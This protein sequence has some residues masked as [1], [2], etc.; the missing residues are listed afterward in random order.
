M[1]TKKPDKTAWQELMASLGN[2]GEIIC[3]DIDCENKEETEVTEATLD[4]SQKERQE[5]SVHWH[6]NSDE[7]EIVLQ[8][9][10]VRIGVKNNEEGELALFSDAIG[11]YSE[12]TNKEQVFPFNKIK[13][14]R[15]FEDSLRIWFKGKLL[16]DVFEGL[17]NT[18]QWKE[19]LELRMAKHI[20]STEQTPV[21][22]E[23][24][25]QFCGKKI[26]RNSKFCN[27][28]GQENKYRSREE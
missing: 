18:F 14:V 2:E 28:C 17:E 26:L 20:M 6:F 4:L 7:K 24:F 3:N 23:C 1:A 12:F 25:C 11:F 16:L 19:E 15:A 8:E 13:E 21:S 5:K 27:F 10:V 9:K 22:Q